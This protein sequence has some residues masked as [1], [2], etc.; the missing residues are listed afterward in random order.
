[1]IELAEIVAGWPLAASMALAVAAQGLRAGRRRGALNE[2]LHELRRPLQ[3]LVL[4]N[5]PGGGAPGEVESSVQLATVA[6]ERLDR[7]V[8]GRSLPLP[9]EAIELRVLLE[10]AVRRWR[11]RVRLSG[12]SLDL[13]WRAG[14]AVVVGDRADLAQALDNLIVNAIEHGGPTISVEA[15]PR[16]G[17]VRIVVAD[18]GSASRPATRRDTPAEVIARLSGRRRH[19]HGLTVVRRVAAAHEGRFA[20]R[21]SERGSLAVLELPLAG[22][23]PS[24]V[25]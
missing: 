9:S 19:G 20:L 12:G 2:A 21:R 15:R 24:R 25:A 7:E 17:R 16:A 10:S 18:S 5:D 22:E 14:R 13:R 3:A 4:A 1:M 8:N 6:L 11:A 23:R